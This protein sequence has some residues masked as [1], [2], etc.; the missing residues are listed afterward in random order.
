MGDVVLALLLAKRDLLGGDDAALLPRPDV[1]LVSNGDDAAE[2]MLVPLATS[3]RDIGL[4][5]RHTWKATRN[6]GKQ[7]KEAAGNRAR[8]AVILGDELQNNEAVVKDLDS[9]EQRTIP[10]ADLP[11]WLPRHLAGQ[12]R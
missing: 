8:T 12:G 6:I 7:L 3:L 10:L 2:S 5:T 4:H 9:G 1:F 11:A